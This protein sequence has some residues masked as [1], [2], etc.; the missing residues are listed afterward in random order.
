M[1]SIDAIINP[2]VTPCLICGAQQNLMPCGGG[3]FICED[4][5]EEE[6]RLDRMAEE[7]TDSND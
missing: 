1:Q 6:L 3:D 5:Y 2:Y 4:C 7:E